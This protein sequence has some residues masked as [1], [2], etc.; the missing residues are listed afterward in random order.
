MSNLRQQISSFSIA[1]HG[2]LGDIEIS[3]IKQ[4]KNIRHDVFG[5]EELAKSIEGKGLL[6]PIVVRTMIGYF[7][8]VAGNRRYCACKALGL[9]KILCHIIELDD[10]QAFEVSLIENIQRKRISPLDEA[11][12]F[13]SYVYDF[14]W[15]GISDLASKI[16]KSM[17]YITKRIKLL[18]LSSD[19]LEAIMNR[20]L[21]TSLA[22]EL[23]SVK[24]GNK[25]SELAGLI[26]NRRLS[27]RM[28]RKLVKEVNDNER[29]LKSFYETDYINHIKIAE[30]SFDKSITAIKN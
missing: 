8:V 17:S 4:A 25:Q 20:R 28:A 12:A 10:K 19:V 7:E 27:L 14:G 16:G 22:E 21:D 11:T 24:D 1:S 3:K 5:I 18:N 15:G 9:K 2:F 6:Q 13:K 30:R 23:L 26:A 29:D